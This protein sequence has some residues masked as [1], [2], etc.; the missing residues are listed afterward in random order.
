M[1][2]P[3]I[4]RPGTPWR[5][6]RVWWLATEVFSASSRV[7]DREYKRDAYLSPGVDEVWLVDI[8]EHALFASTPRW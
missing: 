7:Y 3:A 2:F 8:D 5:S 4:Y 1:V 6:M